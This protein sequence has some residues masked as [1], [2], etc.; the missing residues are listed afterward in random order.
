[1]RFVENVLAHFNRTLAISMGTL[2]VALLVAAAFQIGFG[3]APMRRMR[4]ALGAIR[5]GEAHRLP[6]SFPTEVQPLVDD[7]NALIDTNAA[8]VRRARTQ[9]GNLAHALK[10]PLAVLADEARCL[11]VRGDASGASI[12]REQTARMSRQ[13]DY[14]LTRARAAAS[15]GV[16]GAV[17]N[18]L[19]VVAPII[20]AME[21]LYTF[22]ALAISSDIDPALPALSILSI[23]RKCWPI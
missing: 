15:A 6:N 14:Q 9:A 11:D 21:R 20:T 2:A 13:I 3:L 7:L 1:M 4:L 16:P 23:F 17:S 5:A 18:V 10:T 22:R 12:I 19:N 8:M